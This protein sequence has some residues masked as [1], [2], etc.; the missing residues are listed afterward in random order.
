VGVGGQ[1]L[2]EEGE[3]GQGLGEEHLH[4]TSPPLVRALA[5]RPV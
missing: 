5:K 2:E 3:G 4:L 1:G